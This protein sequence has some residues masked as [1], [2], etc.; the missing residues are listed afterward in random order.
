MDDPPQIAP[1]GHWSGRLRPSG[2][3]LVEAVVVLG[4]EPSLRDP[5]VLDVVHLHGV[6]PVEGLSL[7]LRGQPAQSDGMTVIGD[8][9]VQLQR[10]GSTT[11]FEESPEEPENLV[12]P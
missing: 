12:D 11:E 1:S 10:E 6:R 9:V 5:A 3:K 8:D 2:P 7:P 4:G